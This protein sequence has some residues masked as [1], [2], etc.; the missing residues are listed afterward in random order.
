TVIS[1]AFAQR[2][3]LPRYGV[4][5]RVEDGVQLIEVFNR[6]V[7]FNAPERPDLEMDDP[8]A[9]RLV[10]QILAELKPDVVHYHSFLGFSMALARELYAGNGHDADRIVVLQQQPE[11]VDWIWREVGSRRRSDARGGGP[12]RVGFIGSLYP[13]K[14]LHVLVDALQ[15]FARGEVEGHLFG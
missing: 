8:H 6:D 3:D 1:A 4:E 10:A 15:R 5:A 13:H 12:L 9:S 2:P 14:G 7:V 11:T